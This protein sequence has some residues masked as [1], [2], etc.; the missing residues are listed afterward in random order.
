MYRSPTK[1]V[2][3]GICAQN[4]G[5]ISMLDLGHILIFCELSP[6]CSISGN[7]EN[8]FK[9]SASLKIAIFFYNIKTKGRCI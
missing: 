2:L 3:T 9:V 8:N 7:F 4:P 5:G 6:N 1:S